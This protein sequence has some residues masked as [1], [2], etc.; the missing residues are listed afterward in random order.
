M[1]PDNE[2]IGPLDPLSSLA[3]WHQPSTAIK[4]SQNGSQGP[5]SQNWGIVVTY[6]W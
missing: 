2:I 6:S 3:P 4:L 5:N 1:F